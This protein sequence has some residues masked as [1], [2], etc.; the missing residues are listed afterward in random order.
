MFIVISVKK[1]CSL[2]A[3]IAVGVTILLL[4]VASCG[5]AV[6]LWRRYGKCGKSR[7]L[8]FAMLVFDLTIL[9]EEKAVDVQI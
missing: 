3:V 9:L 8:A 1:S 4:S 7:L 5:L 6:F 2:T